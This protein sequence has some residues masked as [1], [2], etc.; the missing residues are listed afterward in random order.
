MI[1]LSHTGGRRHSWYYVCLVA[2]GWRA[3]IDYAIGLSESLL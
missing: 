1:E 2:M 3:E